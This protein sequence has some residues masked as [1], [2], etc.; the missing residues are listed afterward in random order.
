MQRW[1]RVSQ[2]RWLF[3]RGGTHKQIAVHSLSGVPVHAYTDLRLQ[4]GGFRMLHHCNGVHADARMW[5]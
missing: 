2:A 4:F 3:W 1:L 5:A